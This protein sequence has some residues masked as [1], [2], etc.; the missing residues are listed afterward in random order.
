MNVLTLL[1]VRAR[2]LHLDE[3]DRATLERRVVFAVDRFSDRLRR[4]DVAFEDLNGPRGGV[5]VRCHVR[6]ALW[7]G[8]V[9][10]AE[11]RGES[12]LEA[13]ATALSRVRRTMAR[14]HDRGVAK[15]RRSSPSIRVM[16]VDE[17][18][19]DLAALATG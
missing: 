8:F 1:H 15:E 5:D 14:A 10:D 9:L 7:D 11:A 3:D 13:A 6:I 18:T 17:S 19:S 16:A 12:P 4:V 2:G